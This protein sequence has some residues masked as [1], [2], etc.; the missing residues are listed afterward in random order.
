MRILREKSK[1]QHLNLTLKKKK[2][3]CLRCI[4]WFMLEIRMFVIH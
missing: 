3:P 2:K 4:A 1:K